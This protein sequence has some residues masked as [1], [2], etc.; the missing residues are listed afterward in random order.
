MSLT[1]VEAHFRWVLWIAGVGTVLLSDKIWLSAGTV[2]EP[3][4][5]V[6]D[7]YVRWKKLDLLETTGVTTKCIELGPHRG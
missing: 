4:L 5:V 2:V 6:L 1:S 3:R 7:Q